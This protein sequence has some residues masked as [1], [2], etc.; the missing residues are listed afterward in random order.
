MLYLCSFPRYDGLSNLELGGECYWPSHCGP[1]AIYL[2]V[3]PHLVVRFQNWTKHEFA[4]N[5]T[6][7]PA[8]GLRIPV[9]DFMLIF[10]SMF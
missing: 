8:V 2:F 10:N 6:Y 4:P 1:I 3:L 5:V 7:D 9:N